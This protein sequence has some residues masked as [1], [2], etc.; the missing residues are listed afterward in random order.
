MKILACK[1][2]M[3]VLGYTK[4]M[5]GG[6]HCGAGVASSGSAR[7]CHALRAC[8]ARPSGRQ[9]VWGQSGLGNILPPVQGDHEQHQGQAKR[10]VHAT[11]DPGCGAGVTSAA[12]RQANHQGQRSHR[13]LGKA[14]EN[15]QVD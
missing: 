14:E 4:E 13:N 12:C 15:R 5:G 10:L 7:R 6:N 11:D 8:L 3:E 2:E 9:G 1:T